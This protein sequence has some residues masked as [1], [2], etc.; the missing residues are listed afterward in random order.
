MTERASDHLAAIRDRIKPCIHGGLRLTSEDT[1][2][3]VR[4][5]NTVLEL[6]RETEAENRML[7]AAM[8]ARAAGKPCLRLVSPST[9][10]DA[11]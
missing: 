11:A 6:V 5:L 3:F 8:H 1:A 4:R 10:G 2:S 9:G 7:E